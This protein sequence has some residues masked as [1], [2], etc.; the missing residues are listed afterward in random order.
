[1]LVKNP[2]MGIISY[3]SGRG[4]WIWDGAGLA[5]PMDVREV[6]QS[7]L[8]YAYPTSLRQD[9][10]NDAATLVNRLGQTLPV[11]EVWGM[12]DRDF[13]KARKVCQQVIVE[14]ALC[15]NPFRIIAPSR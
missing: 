11:V 14:G 6:K 3:F 15:V 8:R 2:E 5:Q 7:L 10:I 9:A 13:D 12:E 4:A 1:V